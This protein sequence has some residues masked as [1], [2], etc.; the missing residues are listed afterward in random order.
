MLNLNKMKFDF[1][2]GNLA[3]KDGICETLVTNMH[4]YKMR[5]LTYGPLRLSCIQEDFYLK[6]DFCKVAC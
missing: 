2:S 4:N 5:G 1:E 6:V 3:D